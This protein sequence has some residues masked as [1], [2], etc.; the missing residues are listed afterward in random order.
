MMVQDSSVIFLPT[1]EPSLDPLDIGLDI[2]RRVALQ[3]DYDLFII[4]TSC[5]VQQHLH[6]LRIHV[7][8]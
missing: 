1:L 6:D 2:L 7:F 8:L 4:R 3:L 5:F